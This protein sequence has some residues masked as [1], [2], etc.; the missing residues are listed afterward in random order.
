MSAY[1]KPHFPTCYGKPGS[2]RNAA[3]LFLILALLLTSCRS[4]ST[5]GAWE[6]SP[7]I[8]PPQELPPAIESFPSFST[9]PV[10]SGYQPI[11]ES[12]LGG[13]PA[14]RLHLN[15]TSSAI[16]V[17]D[18]RSGELW[19]S[20]PA[21]LAENTGT[22][23]AWRKLIEQPVQVSYTDGERFQAKNA[24]PENARMT[25]Q[26][27]RDGVRVT[28]V[29]EGLDLAFDVVYAL[30][31]DCLEATII[32][33][34]IVEDGDNSLVAIDLLAFLGATHDGEPGYIVFPDGSGALMYFDTPHPPEAQKILASI[35]GVDNMSGS[36]SS[37]YSENLVMPVFGLTRGA[38]GFVGMI[39]QGDFDANLGIARSGKG[40]NYN[41]IWADFIFRRQGRFSLTGGQPAWLYQP[42]RIPGDRQV[43]FCFLN[44]EKAN[45]VTMAAR[46]RQYLIEERGAVRLADKAKSSP[47]LL[48]LIFFMGIERRTWF[49][50]DMIV[51]TRFSDVSQIMQE[52]IS[53]GVKRADVNLYNWNMGGTSQE[54][55]QRL[56]VDERLGGDV[57]LQQLAKELEQLGLNLY[58]QDDYLQVMPNTNDIQPFLDTVRGVDG[59]PIGDAEQGYYLN[60][61]V[62]LRGFALRDIP[63]I[64]TLGADGLLL[65][66]FA[67]LALPDKN[68]V[69]PLARE[70]F[71]ASWMQ[72]ASI[73]REQLGLAAMTGGNVYAIP[74]ADRLDFVT[75]DSTHYDLFDDTIPWLQIVAHGLVSY[76]GSPFNLNSNRQWM[77]LRHI[78]YG[79]LPTFVLTQE[80]SSRLSRTAA[81][82]IYSSRYGYWEAEVVRHYQEIEPLAPLQTQFIV[83][84]ERLANG[85]YRTTY[86]SGVQVIVNYN[87]T[88]YMEDA[89]TIPPQD[90][91]V[92]EGN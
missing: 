63:Q 60:P 16:I 59:L 92:V 6:S 75:L 29:F 25:Y 89:L 46:Y 30:K 90:F 86:E 41:H 8:N 78:E 61:Q 35:Y 1:T 12:T 70:N 31:Q 74:Y 76:T 40:L 72:I 22:T 80:S 55:P 17:E 82:D 10:E 24:K 64:A 51:M 81:N 36:Q 88:T 37:M 69:F 56:P 57:E 14:L 26:P 67:S 85:V 9:S 50:A 91:I 45:Y 28:Y 54:Y 7:L 79:A 21:D 38:A 19:R 58:L 20:S 77:F 11:A 4:Y 49:I 33:D 52:L 62:A 84:H 44:G 3:L 2:L 23:A 18:L 27:V 73:S 42:D 15:Q 65:Q 53:Q 66:N 47:P 43:R 39:T 5:N 32:S 68:S 34:S 87:Q 71:A 13:E 83:N 48:N